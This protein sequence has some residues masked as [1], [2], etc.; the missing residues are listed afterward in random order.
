MEVVIITC[1]RHK[2]EAGKGVGKFG[3]ERNEVGFQVCYDWSLTREVGCR[4]TTSKGSHVILLG[5]IFGLLWLILS[6]MESET[7]NREAGSS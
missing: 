3:S 5:N 1:G 2:A 4:L 7:K 6:W